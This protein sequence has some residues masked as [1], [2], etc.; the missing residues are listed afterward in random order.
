MRLTIIWPIACQLYKIFRPI[1]IK[2]VDDP[3]AEWDDYIMSIA[4]KVFGY[5]A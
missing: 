4:D 5:S 2:A 3:N 1:L